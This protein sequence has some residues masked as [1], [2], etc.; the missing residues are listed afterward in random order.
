MNASHFDLIVIGTGPSASTVAQKS[1][2]DGKRV[3]VVEAREFGG[4]CALRGCNPKK[5]YTNAANLFDRAW[6]AKGELIEFDQLRIDW[7]KLHAFKREFTQPVVEKTEASY[8]EQGIATFHGR[9][10]FS[11]RNTIVVQ[12]RALSAERI[13]IG[14]GAA[15]RPLDLPGAERAIHSDEFLELAEIPKRVAFVGGGYVSMEFACVAARFG[16]AVTVLQR[17][18]QILTPFD[19]DLVAQLA[20]YSAERGILIQTQSTVTAI[21]EAA[22]E[23]SRVV[24]YE[25]SDHS[26]SV[27]ADLV[28]HGAGRVPN[29]DGMNL[30]AG[31]VEFGDRGIVVDEFMRSV[32]NPQVF[33]AGDC[34]DT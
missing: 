1:R 13:F 12:G 11:G 8:R 6:G 23:R 34:A 19:P 20:Q 14:A 27:E 21:E 30:S 22:D 32:S 4:T 28:V 10:S 17:G 31:D 33:A 5:V 7:Q 2:A 24:R 15:P 16:A 9:A 25:Q 26:K 29:L 3:A 18:P